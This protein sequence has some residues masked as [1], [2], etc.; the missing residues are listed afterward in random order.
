MKAFII[1]VLFLFMHVDG[2]ILTC[3]GCCAIACCPASPTIILYFACLCTCVS[4][5]GA[6]SPAP[7]I[8]MPICIAPVGI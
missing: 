6:V 7:P 4:T 3:S 1:L 5:A 2:G 8:C